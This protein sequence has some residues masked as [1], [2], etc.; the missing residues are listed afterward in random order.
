MEQLRWKTVSGKTGLVKVK[1]INK[2]LHQT[3][4]LIL[5]LVVV[6]GGEDPHHLDS[7][8]PAGHRGYIGLPRLIN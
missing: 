4:N 8:L 6:A 3:T 2:E 1:A 5:T 7:S